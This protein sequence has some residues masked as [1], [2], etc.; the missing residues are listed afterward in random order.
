RETEDVRLFEAGAAFL[1]TGEVPRVGWVMTGKRDD[2]WSGDA[3]A[4]DF[5]DAKGIA[6]LLAEAFGVSIVARATDTRPWFVR[7]RAADL[8]I[9]NDSA[10][11]DA[12]AIGSIGQLRP[13]LA[14]ARG[15]ASGVA[16][17][18]GELDPS[19]LL[20]AAGTR[21]LAI[22]PLPCHPSIVRDLS[23]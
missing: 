10:A 23:I 5:F 13:E 21:D 12:L 7:G 14:T 15:L 20:R 18:G 1:P 4:V 8:F 6:A 16:V 9:G 3:G 17:Y 2:H 11:T 19:A 22:E